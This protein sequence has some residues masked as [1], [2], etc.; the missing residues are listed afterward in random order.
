MHSLASLWHSRFVCYFVHNKRGPR[1]AC[2]SV[3]FSL[4]QFFS[5]SFEGL[6]QTWCTQWKGIVLMKN[7][8][9]YEKDPS[10]NKKVIANIKVLHGR[11]PQQQQRRPG[12]DNTSTFF[13]RKTDELK[14]KNTNKY[15]SPTFLVRFCW[16]NGKVFL[17]T[18]LFC[19]CIH[20]FRVR[21]YINL[22]QNA[23]NMQ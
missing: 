9:E 16:M 7:V 13:L 1:T 17:R 4:S 10:S 2:S 19:T 12:Y 15:L 14:I 23:F 20:M 5:K 6:G 21:W 8:C 11:R 3:L 18:F 22:Y